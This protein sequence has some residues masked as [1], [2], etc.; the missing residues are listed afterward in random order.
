MTHRWSSVTPST[1]VDFTPLTFFNF[2]ICVCHKFLV[3]TCKSRNSCCLKLCLC[4]IFVVGILFIRCYRVRNVGK[5]VACFT[6]QRG[7]QLM[8]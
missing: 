1:L 2:H 7:V 5:C 3:R 4:F 8:D 6:I